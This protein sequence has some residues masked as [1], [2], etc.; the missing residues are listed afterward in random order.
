MPS[1]NV[2]LLANTLS[3]FQYFD[4]HFGLGHTWGITVLPSLLIL[5]NHFVKTAI[6][7]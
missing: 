3:L 2:P 5:G 1:A 7:F 4:L 6:A